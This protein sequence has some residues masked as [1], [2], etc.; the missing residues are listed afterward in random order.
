MSS[1]PFR[2]LILGG[3]PAGIEAALTLH[4][5]APQIAVELL[6][7][8][9]NLVHDPLSVESPFTSGAVRS[10]PLHILL[11]DAA[12]VRQATLAS[13]D[14]AARTAWM[15]DGRPLGYDALLVATGC[16]ARAS[17]PEAN[18]FHGRDGVRAMFEVMRGIEAGRVRSVGF[19]APPDATWTLPL[20]ELAL[21]LSRRV[22]ELR[23]PSIEIVVATPEQQPLEALGPAASATVQHL[24]TRERI[25]FCGDDSRPAT[26]RTVALASAVGR[27]TPG[28]PADRGGFIPVD[29]RGA[30]AGVPGVW[31]AGD[32]TVS[33]F[34]Q[35]GLATQQAETAALSIIAAAGLGPRPPARDPVL[36]TM[37]IVSAQE[38][39]Y[40]ERWLRHGVLGEVSRRPLWDPPGKIAGRRIGPLLDAF[41]RG[42]P[43]V[44]HPRPTGDLSVS[45]QPSTLS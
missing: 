34:K 40:F 39:W 33:Y 2:V 43:H 19:V 45:A 9:R 30:V 44:T 22:R 35:A 7:S 27:F 38:H 42:A 23:W 16:S 20:Y 8:D 28:L 41:D 6:A 24:L 32:G 15:Q 31:A 3:G 37:L 29:D 13:I 12:H 18:V 25:D 4:E 11:G 5:A 10:Y 17:V 1:A 36:R 14:A 21:Q 26:D